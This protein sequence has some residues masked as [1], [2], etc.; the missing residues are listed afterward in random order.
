LVH[1]DGSNGRK[2]SDSACG[3]GP[4]PGQEEA[5]NIKKVLTATGLGVAVMAML[6]AA[7]PTLAAAKAG[8]TSSGNNSASTGWDIS[9]PQCPSYFPSGGSFGIVGVTNGRPWGI[10]TC[11]KAE[12]QWAAQRS[13]PPALYM[14]TANPATQSSFYWPSTGDRSPALCQDGTS[15]TD[16]GCAYDYGW[17]AAAD[18][19]NDVVT[20][21]DLNTAKG[22]SWWLDVETGNS[23]WGDTYSNAADIQGSIDYLRAQGVSQVG[24]YSTISQWDQIT[25]GYTIAN[26]SSYA[27]RW[28]PEFTSPYLLDGSP[29]WVPGASNLK[30]AQARCAASYSFTGATVRL[31]QYPSQGFD[32]DYLCP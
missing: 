7:L 23:W 29:D 1:G 5:V 8:N 4:L 17:H 6:A 19:F 18:A 2:V 21:V 20:T 32:A 14:N 27:V 24:I 16:P 11:L 30:G 28:Q 10:N 31:T 12:Y 15:T 13:S 25:G 9:W 26:E 22:H 3:D